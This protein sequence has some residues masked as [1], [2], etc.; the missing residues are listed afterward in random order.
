[1]FHAS[2]LGYDFTVTVTITVEWR[3]QFQMRIL[4]LI[5]VDVL[6]HYLTY[7]LYPELRGE[8]LTAVT[9]KI[10]IFLDGNLAKDK[11]GKSTEV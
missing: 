8:V 5:V 10:S 6:D 4:Y 3:S 9:V 11:K 1:L 2:S 7:F